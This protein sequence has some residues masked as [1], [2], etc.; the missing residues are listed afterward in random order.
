MINIGLFQAFIKLFRPKS[1]GGVVA[2]GCANMIFVDK[3]HKRSQ[4]FRPA[5]RRAASI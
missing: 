5:D 1:H 4:C 3:M 2:F